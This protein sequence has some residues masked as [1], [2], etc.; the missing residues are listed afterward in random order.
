MPPNFAAIDGGRN[1]AHR[2]GSEA[3]IKLVIV[4]QIKK[5]A[6]GKLWDICTRK[7]DKIAAGNN[8]ASGKAL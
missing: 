2:T 8:P 3:K 5:I 4:P 1:P 6:Q 7:S